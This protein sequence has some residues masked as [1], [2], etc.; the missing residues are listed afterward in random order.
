LLLLER[1]CKHTGSRERSTTCPAH[2]RC[3]LQQAPSMKT[4]GAL[5]AHNSLAARNL[6]GFGA[7]VSA[8]RLDFCL[9]WAVAHRRSWPVAC[10]YIAAILPLSLTF[11]G[12]RIPKI[13]LILWEKVVRVA[14][15]CL[16][17]RHFRSLPFYKLL[18]TT[19]TQLYAR[20]HFDIF[21]DFFVVQF[22]NLASI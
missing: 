5:L 12:S 14:S 10:S 3:S 8:L 6:H 19:H 20:A 4:P 13:T 17:T 18:A 1:S 15:N 7:S 11:S 9:L 22:L 16:H 21:D 2:S